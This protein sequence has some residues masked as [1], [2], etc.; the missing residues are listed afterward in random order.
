MVPLLLRQ[1]RHRAAL[2]LG[3]L[4]RMSMRADALVAGGWG[5]EARGLLAAGMRVSCVAAGQLPGVPWG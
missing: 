3:E 5:A 2:N 4:A 1:V